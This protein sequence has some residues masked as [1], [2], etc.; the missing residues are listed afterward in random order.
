MRWSAALLLA[1]LSTPVFACGDGGSQMVAEKANDLKV[2]AELEPITVSKPFALDLILCGSGDKLSVEADAWM[3][4]H[5]HGMNYAPVVT[6]QGDGRYAV[7]NMVFHMPGLW[8]VRVNVR[9]QDD[10][11]PLTYLLD[12]QVK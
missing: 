2:F 7:S 9:G 1:S 6:S 5:K 10:A 11:Q 8:Q 4:R 3:P 12:V